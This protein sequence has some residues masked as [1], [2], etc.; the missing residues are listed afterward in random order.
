MEFSWTKIMSFQYLLCMTSRDRCH[1]RHNYWPDVNKLS[2]ML[3]LVWMD[4]KSM[5]SILMVVRISENKRRDI[6]TQSSVLHTRRLQK[7]NW[8]E[9]IFFIHINQFER[10]KL[11][12]C[13]TL[14]ELKYLWVLPCLQVIR[15]SYRVVYLT[16]SLTPNISWGGASVVADVW[17]RQPPPEENFRVFYFERVI[18]R[19]VDVP[20]PPKI[21]PFLFHLSRLCRFFMKFWGCNA[22]SELFLNGNGP[23]CSLPTDS[24]A[25]ATSSFFVAQ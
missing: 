4:Q 23:L 24:D 8:F 13:S 18:F 6:T 2:R 11:Y 5:F 3:R 12:S 16:R 7:V 15:S 14:T 19:A 21:F 9:I 25:T 1:I 10:E 17:G 22:P 20:F